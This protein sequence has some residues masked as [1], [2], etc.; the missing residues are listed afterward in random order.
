MNSNIGS[1]SN[2]SIFNKKINYLSMINEYNNTEKSI[3][4]NNDYGM[5]KIKELNADKNQK[6]LEDMKNQ[7]KIKKELELKKEYEIKEKYQL[8]FIDKKRNP[9]YK[10]TKY[11]GINIFF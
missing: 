10:F 11:S 2:N 3:D 5:L 1:L 7:E 9:L 6:I 8:D 4:F